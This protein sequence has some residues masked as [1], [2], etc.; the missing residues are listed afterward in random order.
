MLIL[1]A[2]ANFGLDGIATEGSAKNVLTVGAGTTTFNNN[3]GIN[4]I[5]PYSGVGPTFDGRIKPDI[6]V[7]FSSL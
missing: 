6:I 3:V 7:S 2:A 4:T 1:F 5:A